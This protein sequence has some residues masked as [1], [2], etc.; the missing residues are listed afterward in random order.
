[1]HKSLWLAFLLLTCGS[2]I[3]AD[4]TTPITLDMQTVSRMAVERN[5]AVKSAEKDV[6]T[7]RYQV[8]EAESYKHGRAGLKAAYLHMND[9]ILI[10]SPS[11]TLPSSVPLLGGLSLTPPPV[12]IAPQEVV[13]LTLEAGYPIYT[14]RKIDYA[15]SQARSGVAAREALAEDAKSG[16]IL[17]SERCYLGVLLAKHVVNVN[18]QALDS[19]KEHLNHARIAYDKGIVAQYD[20]IRAETA[21][22]EQEKRLTEARNTLDLALAALRT[23]LDL[24]DGTPLEIRGSL[25]EPTEPLTF[26][27]ARDLAM[28]SSRILSAVDAKLDA[29]R[30]AEKVEQSGQKPQVIAVARQELLTGNIAQ[31]D[32]HWLI[33]VE[34]G[35][36]LDD[37]GIRKSRVKQHR[38]EIER[39]I[40]DRQSVADQIELAIRNS[41]LEL[42][43]ARSALELARKSE[44]LA[45]ESLRL[46]TK[47]FGVGTGTSLE[48]LD[49]NVSLAAAQVGEYQC[50]YRLDMAYLQLHRYLNDISAV[51]LEVQR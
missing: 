22:K 30:M 16:A 21:V 15:V 23:S 27:Q 29:Q 49:A 13:H 2:P 24:D 8:R 34:V 3:I 4:S 41:F 6:Q 44:Q 42:D 35:F 9:D 32:P 28:K 7:A 17:D 5:L 25:F 39:T 46:A 31:T 10:N 33:G 40:I 26:E 1:M 19:Y 11:V 50:L 20:V 43:S 36:D 51:V 47:R 45:Q 12:E 18:Q 48:V 37:G 14:G 38:S